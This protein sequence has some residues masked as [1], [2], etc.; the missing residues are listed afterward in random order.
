M[1]T[2]SISLSDLPPFLSF[3]LLIPFL[4]ANTRNERI[5][6]LEFSPLE[7]LKVLEKKLSAQHHSKC[8]FHSLKVVSYQRWAAI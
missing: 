4:K 6:S 2:N 1:Q 7:Q 5:T 8:F 3:S